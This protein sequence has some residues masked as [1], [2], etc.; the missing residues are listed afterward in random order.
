MAKT[1]SPSIVT[2]IVDRLYGDGP[3]GVSEMCKTIPFTYK[4]VYTKALEL[5]KLGLANKDDN[6]VWSLAEGVTPDTLI[7]G[8]KQMPGAQVTGA[9]GAPPGEE[10]AAATVRE[11]PIVRGTGVP[12]DQNNLFIQE[13]K[14]I[15]VAPKEAIPT[16]A[17][18]FFSGDI[19][20]LRWLE[21]VLKRDA[22]GFITPHQRRLIISWWSHTRGLPYNPDEFFPALDEEGKPR[23]AGAKGE[24]VEEKPER[25]LDL[26]VGWKVDRDKDG[27]WIT[28][29]GGPMSYQEA[30]DAA[31]RRALI[32]SYKRP[33][34]DQEAEVEGTGEEGVRVGKGAKKTESLVEYMMKKMID[35]MLEGKKGQE[36]G[37]SETVRKLTE[38]I[39]TME[40]EKQEDRFERMEGLIA[41]I[42]NRDPW[43][44]YD[45]IESMKQRLGV[46]GATVTDQSPA[47][48]LIKDSTDKVD[49]GITRLLGVIERTALHSETFTPE[50]TRSATEREGKA[51][52]LLGEVSQRE[53]SRDL[54]RGA[55]GV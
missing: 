6:G 42:V 14:N 47:V 55:F 18:I 17:N 24:K 23:T 44:D 51:T 7:T 35:N 34:G 33:G 21:Q 50:T 37:D 40:R 54:R 25:R 36:D 9:E 39:D 41:S 29:P 5:A 11:A 19:D 30:V 26:G 20:D 49:K 53:K 15:G 13:L 22:A 27:A 4:S 8:E 28:V 48:Q 32:D 38:R 31:E 3:M 43:E 46:G 1:K 52:E 16:V 2:Q 10:G 12:L 45:K